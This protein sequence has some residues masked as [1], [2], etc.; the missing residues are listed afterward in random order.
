M[1]GRLAAAHQEI[2]RCHPHAERAIRETGAEQFE[3][4]GIGR[5]FELHDLVGHADRIGQSRKTDGSNGL[6]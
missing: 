2:K 3:G 4:L 6:A 1:R 5:G